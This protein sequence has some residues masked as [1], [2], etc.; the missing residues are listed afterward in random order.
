M[1]LW[2][3]LLLMVDF[4]RFFVF[5]LWLDD[6][7]DR[8]DDPVDLRDFLDDAV[9]DDLTVSCVDNLLRALLWE[10]SFSVRVCELGWFRSI[11]WRPVSSIPPSSIISAACSS[12]SFFSLFFCFSRFRLLL[13]SSSSLSSSCSSVTNNEVVPL[14][15]RLVFRPCDDNE[16]VVLPLRSSPTVLPLTSRLEREAPSGGVV[17]LCFFCG[18]L[19]LDFLLPFFFLGL[20]LAVLVVFRGDVRS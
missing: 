6:R 18:L 12:L 2:A 20:L 13:R 19:L 1:F 9:F 8:L 3:S 5:F 4:S 16:T 10:F 15:L 17:I 11:L 7:L 14:A